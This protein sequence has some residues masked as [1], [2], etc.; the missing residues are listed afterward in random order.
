MLVTERPDLID[1]TRT[2]NRI[3]YIPGR[4]LLNLIPTDTEQLGANQKALGEMGGNLLDDI[5]KECAQGTECGASVAE[6]KEQVEEISG[7]VVA[8]G[9]IC[10]KNYKG[11]GFFLYHDIP[12]SKPFS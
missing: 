3:V 1:P 11:S 6:F 2:L 5:K 10:S 4:E 8:V 7:A 12:R 9:I